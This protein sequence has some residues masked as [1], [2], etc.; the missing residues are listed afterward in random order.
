[1]RAPLSRA[2]G[3]GAGVRA[4]IVFLALF[5]AACSM[6]QPTSTALGTEQNPVKL[7]LAPTAETQKVL[8]AGEP[9]AK[10]IEKE[11]GLRVKLSV[12]T[13]YAA[14]I[15]AMGTHNVDVGWLAPLAYVLARE[16]IGAD[17][18]V[19]NVRGGSTTSA[20]QIV[21]RAD[22][23]ITSL[24]GLRGK[25]FA[26]A[27]DTS[28]TG[29]H[30]PTALFWAAGIDPAAS[31]KE[32]VFVGGDDRVLLAVYNRQA[33]G[34]AVVGERALGLAGST[35]GV[36]TAF[37]PLPTDLA[38]Q[39]RVI[40]RTDPIPNDVVGVRSGV[41]P[42]LGRQIRDGLLRVAA[43]PPGA[44]ALR[45]LYGIDGLAPVTDAELASLRAAVS[46]L[47][48]DLDAVLTPR[49]RGG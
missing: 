46:L 7:A 44:A 33:D 47:D 24:D 29:Y 30:L 41:S 42:E 16:R 38:E 25:R 13:S 14:T 5:S 23:G 2:Q 12:P 37:Q 48:L 49:R 31:F 22:S 8:V 15:E 11:T 36:S 32:T 1:M 43:T 18:L 35:A 3:E 39:I 27:D 6:V 9:L 28:V 17:A 20:G 4:L 34:G 10:L 26:F 19:A 45:D 40:A 21:V